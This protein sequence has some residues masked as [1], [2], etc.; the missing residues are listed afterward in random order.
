MSDPQVASLA[1]ALSQSNAR[2][3]ARNTPLTTMPDDLRRRRLGVVVDQASLAAAMAPKPALAALAA[4]ALGF[5]PAVDWRNRNGRNHIT[6]VKDQGNCGS[7]VSFCCAAL[8]EAMAS[9]EHG[10]ALDLSEADLHFCS[11]HG[12]NCGGWWP[13]Q[14]L[15]QIQSRGIPDEAAFPYASAFEGGAPHCHLAPDRDARAVRITSFGS[16][17]DA[18]ARKHHLSTVGPCSA[19]LHV[20]NDFFSYGGGVYHHVSGT[21]AGLHCVEVI[22]Y[23]EADRCWICKNSWG[24]G[25]G[26]AGFFRIA[27]GECGIDTEF[28]FFWGTGT[29]LPVHRGWSNWVPLGAPA[30][31]FTGAPSVISRNSTVCNI[32]V[33]G[34]DNALW[35]KAW[36]N[37]AWHD[38][39][40]H[41]DGGVLASEPAL[42]SMGPNHEHVF[43]RGTDNQ[44]WQ[45]FW[46]AEKGWSG[47]FA[48]GAPPVGF[49][50]APAVISRNSTVC[51][52]YV[53]GSDNA[54]WQKAWFNNAWHDWGRHNDGGVLASEPA[55]GSMGP[56]HEHV[57][58]RGTDN[59]VWQKF[60]TAEKG[61]SGWFALGAP[62]VGF[63]GAPA[64][65]SRNNTVCN[66]YVRGSDN[67]LW[68]K[69]WF[70]N[71][72]HDWGRHNDGGV[73]ASEPAPGSMGP[74]H[75]HVFVRGTDNQ[76]WQKWWN[77]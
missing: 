66:I 20:F 76:V 17:A 77:G 49:Q 59:Q 61:W 73:L 10:Q 68:Q 26:D 50:G 33:R 54:L 8:V 42:G 3:Q 24:P 27:Y 40:R 64:V 62:P 19:I 22:G 70:N 52:I 32:Y 4:G 74:N 67:A 46:T 55:L 57:F 72:W 13:D 71:A 28:P 11:S 58:I 9:I 38:W 51:N 25:W 29:V 37:N 30:G 39:G 31:G 16:L 75:E 23:S 41:N 65:I 69:A 7:C 21:E 36:F 48:L 53:R 1:Q 14:A 34:S 2:W 56:N 47:W 43:I 15:G 18:D 44:V 35:Q 45:K 60:W 63:T 5:D 6:P 12:A